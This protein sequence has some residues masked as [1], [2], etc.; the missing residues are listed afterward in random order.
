MMVKVV[1]GWYGLCITA[2][3]N[4][5]ASGNL[6]FRV[7]KLQLKVFNKNVYYLYSV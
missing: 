3:G 4:L 2:G 6:C 7:F 1:E 5:V